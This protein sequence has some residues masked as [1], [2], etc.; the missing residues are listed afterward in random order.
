MTLA[1]SPVMPKLTKASA[2]RCGSAVSAVAAARERELSPVGMS[3][4][5]VVVRSAGDGAGPVA[6]G[7]HLIRM[8]TPPEPGAG[9]P[10]APQHVLIAVG[11][12]LALASTVIG[13]SRP[14]RSPRSRRSRGR[15][16]DVRPDRV[17]GHPA[18][19]AGVGTDDARVHRTIRARAGRPPPV[20]G[21]G[22][23]SR[24]TVK[25]P[26][27]GLV[28]SLAR[29][30]QRWPERGDGC[31]NPVSEPW[32]PSVPEAECTSSAQDP[33]ASC[34]RRC[35]SHLSGFSVRL[36]EKRREYTR[37]RMVRLAS[38]LV[39]DSVEGYRADHFDGDNV[40]AV[41]DPPELAEGLAFR[42]SIPSDLMALLRDWELGFCPLNAIERSVSDLIDSRGS[43]SV[44]RTAARRDGGGRDRDARAGRRPDR[45]HGQQVAASRSPGTRAPA[46]RTE[47]RTRSTSCS[48][49]RSSSPSCTARRMPVTSTASTTRTSRT[50]TTSSFQWSTAC[51]TT[52][53]SAT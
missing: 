25:R 16:R 45:L 18:R 11:A 44:E 32:R 3:V 19:C 49:T 21:P 37:T 48:S 30:D 12:T 8:R 14:G 52:E 42:Q 2:G 29:C 22:P 10:S 28:H 35:S 9:S 33:S 53:A 27:S 26:R 34:W 50:R 15:G 41:F 39:A 38:Y 47:A 31:R 5:V 13:H 6:A 17:P 46:T 7:H 36:Y 1:R 40:E 24:F 43:N 4:L 20:R 51:S 23:G